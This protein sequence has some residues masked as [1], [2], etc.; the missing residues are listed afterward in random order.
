MNQRL[1]ACFTLGLILTGGLTKLCQGAPADSPE[2]DPTITIHVYNYADVSPKTP[3]EAEKIAAGV[4]GRAG[5]ETRWLD[6]HGKRK[7]S[8]AEPER[9]HSNDIVLHLLP[10][11]M[12]ER[13]GLISE[14]LGFAPGQGPNRLDAYVFYDRAEQLVQQQ[15]AA[16]MTKMALG[17]HEPCVGIGQVLGH[18]I[19]HELGHLLGLETHSPTGIM[20]A[21]WGSADWQETVNGHLSFTPQQA[22][23]IRAEVGRR[24]QLIR[25]FHNEVAG[26]R[27]AQDT[28]G[29]IDSG[30]LT[31]LQHETTGPSVGRVVPPNDIPG[32]QR[33]RLRNLGQ[34]PAVL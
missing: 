31:S 17:V 13:L 3:I 32:G 29:Y 26:G 5:V 2:A 4:F 25:R 22:E 6:R 28:P 30:E 9:F 15:R 21:D 33:A 23:V 16:Q 12:T 27:K 14:R 7:E 10:R 8:S 11:S 34:V 1:R 18:V 20:R 19:A 24:I